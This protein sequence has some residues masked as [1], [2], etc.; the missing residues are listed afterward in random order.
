V[1]H[2]DPHDGHAHGIAVD[3]RRP[4]LVAAL[5]LL[6]VFMV[7]EVVVAFAAGSLA[8]LSDA[9]HM[10]TDAGA[11][12]AALW[13]MRL[14]ERPASERWTFGLKRAEIVAAAINGITLVVIAGVV[15]VEA[16]RRLFAAHPDVAGMPV[17]VVALVGC[18]VNL[19]AAWLIARANRASLNVEGAYQHILTDLYGFVGTVVAGVV[20]LATGWSKADSIASLV[21]VALMAHASWALL[22]ESGHILLEGSPAA[23]DLALVRAHLVEVDHVRDVHDLHAWTITSGMPALSAHV[24]VDDACFHDGHVPQLLDALQA[25]I[26]GHFDVEHS[27]FQFE[28]SSHAGHEHGTHG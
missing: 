1:T 25:C 2:H 11:L 20:I 12:A 8:L 26:G 27:T 21:V 17:L 16:L 5:V 3:A 28:Q 24:V 23:V 6:L 18:V 13:V 7:G 15:L 19:A 10:L 14:A 4:Y 9:G 22:R